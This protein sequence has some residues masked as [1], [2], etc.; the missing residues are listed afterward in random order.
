MTV[1]LEKLLAVRE[2]RCH[3]HC[4]DGLGSA[5]IITAAYASRGLH[6]NLEFVTYDTAEHASATPGPH[7]L[8]ADITPPLARWEEWKEH[9]PVVLDHHD[10]AKAATEGLGGVYGGL[11]DSGASLSYKHAMR[12]MIPEDYPNR[13][14]ILE[15]WARFAFLGMLRDTWKEE[16]DEWR[17][18]CA[19]ASALSFY[20]PKSMLAAASSVD[21]DLDEMLRF[22]RIL[23]QK[24]EWKAVQAARGSWFE[25]FRG[26]KFGYFNCTEKIIS[27]TCHELIDKHGCDVAVSF[28]YKV[29]NGRLDISVSLRSKKP[30]KGG[31]PVNRMAEVHGGG[32]HAPAAG[33]RIKDAS[34]TSFSDL[35]SKV[36][37]AYDVVCETVVREVIET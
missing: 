24:T 9:S 10:T 25:E 18:A 35:V 27:E 28:F 29:E 5:M 11:N 36:R 21:V 17:D 12:P 22:G 23:Y 32:G 16:H 8:W 15:K 2:V 30:E 33:F 3:A 19:L 14:K 34:G 6:P 26:K 13:D 31:V 7:Q 1:E 20:T 37:Q 4:P